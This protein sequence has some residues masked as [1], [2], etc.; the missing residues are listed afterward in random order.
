MKMRTRELF[1]FMRERQS[2]YVKKES[3][4]PKPWTKDPI[5]QQYRFC[6]VYREQDKVTRWIAEYWR[7]AHSKERDLWFAMIVAR[8]LNL[9]HSL[10]MLSWPIPWNE[11]DFIKTLHAEQKRGNNVFNAAYIVSTNGISM[12]KVEYIAK[13]VLTPIWKAR[14]KITPIIRNETLGT[15]PPPTLAQVHTTL[16]HF[17]GLGSFLAAQVIADLKYVEPLK[18]AVD[19]WTWAA[20]GPGSRR[21][22][23]RICHHDVQDGWNEATWL[24]QLQELQKQINSLIQNT[25]TV[26][27]NQRI[28]S[29]VHAQDLQNC[30][31][32]WDK[33]ERVRLGQGRPKQKYNGGAN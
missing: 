29:P 1:S 23:N 32:E 20:S 6:N 21:G 28:L 3:N 4:S 22:L 19:W 12:D 10:I 25:L 18:S 31:C 16:T 30:L 24:A 2:I 15:I 13:L 7:D 17:N 27:R 11:R 26:N 5:L 8:L 9:P 14:E 33:Y